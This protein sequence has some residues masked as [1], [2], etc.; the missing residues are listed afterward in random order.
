MTE[1]LALPVHI[2][3]AGDWHGN[4]LYARA[5]VRYAAE[6][7]AD[8]ILH[9]GDFG[10]TFEEDYLNS[11]SDVLTDHRINLLF[12]DGNHE[13]HWW[14]NRQPLYH[15]LRPLRHNI[16]HL[17]RGF[18]WEW[19]DVRF[20]ALGGAHSV[21]RQSRRDGVSWWESETINS[22]RA[23][24]TSREGPTDVMLSHDCP[25]GVDVPGLND[26]QWPPE[27]IR[28]AEDHRQLLRSVVDVVQ[29]AWLWHGH[30]HT[31]YTAEL[32]LNSRV[33]R[34]EGMGL[35]GGPYADNV[36]VVTL[37]SLAQRIKGTKKGNRG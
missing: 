37:A 20:L 9:L 16:W 32:P 25:A 22:A 33:C 19:N 8:V 4:T 29:P 24:L 3:F 7:G 12:V 5:A 36:S 15:G 30:Y 17:P 31:R 10:Y 26:S 27:E 6:Q 13:D 18:R 21:D 35:D 2:A 28:A 34:V 23:E 1:P 14:L 11:V